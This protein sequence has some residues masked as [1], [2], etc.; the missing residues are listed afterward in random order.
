M[1]H[2]TDTV[3]VERLQLSRAPHADVTAAALEAQR[4][5]GL[6]AADFVVVALEPGRLA[7]ATDAVE[8]VLGEL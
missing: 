7:D 3:T 1:K 4:A 2:G 6:E 8:R 5:A